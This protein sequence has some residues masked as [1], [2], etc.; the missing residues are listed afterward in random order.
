M[1]FFGRQFLNFKGKL[2]KIEE[3]SFNADKALLQVRQIWFKGGGE[4]YSV[5]INQLWTILT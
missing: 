5:K 4:S 1:I 3:Y 2:L